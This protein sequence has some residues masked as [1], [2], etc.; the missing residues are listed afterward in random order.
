[1]LNDIYHIIRGLS[2]ALMYLVLGTY[3]KARNKLI[4]Y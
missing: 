3:Y 2:L 4:N 1:M